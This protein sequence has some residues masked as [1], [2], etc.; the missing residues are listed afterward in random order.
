MNSVGMIYDRALTP[1]LLDVGLRVAT[2]AAGSRDARQLLTVAL[3]DHVSPQEAEGKTKKDLTRV[4]VQPPEPARTMIRWAVQHQHLD[5][6]RAV[7]HFG[8]ILATFPF[9]GVIASIVGRQL[10]LEDSVE[11]QR[12]R[13]EACAVLG[14]RSSIDVGARKVVTTM[15]YLGLLEAGGNKSLR[16]GRQPAVPREL[17]PWVMHALL[18][19]RQV[20]AVGLDEPSRAP[21]LATIKIEN[22]RP[23]GYP[24]LEAHT[25]GS[26]T[27]AVAVRAAA[28]APEAVTPSP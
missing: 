27:V 12:V 8:A 9:A 7:L 18:L 1:D 13:A 16:A 24:L 10:H 26:R 25:E 3:R 2:D 22:G 17:A 6:H 15:R 11:P 5:P 23:N 19:T 21:E 4:W 14:D 28:D 20:G